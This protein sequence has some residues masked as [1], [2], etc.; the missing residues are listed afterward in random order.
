MNWTITHDLEN[1]ILIIK[2][3][4]RID[5]ETAT[6]LRNEGAKEIRQHEYLRCL[7]DHSELEE[8]NLSTMDIYNLPKR[9]A[10]LGIPHDFRMALVVPPHLQND[11][12]FYET[13]CRNNGYFAS[14]FFDNESAL[15]WLKS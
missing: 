9:Y 7:L 10:E 15:I 8:Y 1:H 3:Q 4:G 5:L 11:L 6:Q 14:V 13:V 2:T 12:N